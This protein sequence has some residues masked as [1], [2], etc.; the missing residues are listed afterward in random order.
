MVSLTGVDC[1]NVVED[2]EGEKMGEDWLESAST[3]KTILRS[4]KRGAK[5]GCEGGSCLGKVLG[6]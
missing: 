1:V 5:G 4:M 2:A 3:P 6:V